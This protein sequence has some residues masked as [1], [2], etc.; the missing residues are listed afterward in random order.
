MSTK[1]KLKIVRL[2]PKQVKQLAKVYVESFRNKKEN[3]NKKQATKLIKNYLKKQPD[4]V[5]A[6]IF[7]DKLIG[8]YL[9]LIKPWWD[10]NHLV[11]TEL[12]VDPKFQK[13]GV[14]KKLFKA[15][16]LKSKKKYKATV[17]EGITFA[18]QNFPMNW[19]KC[20]GMRQSK[21]L[22]FIDGSINIMLRNIK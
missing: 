21:D 13:A 15:M 6:A 5:L 19:Y 18:K 11:E 14:G 7:K 4:M 10:G 3:W 9:C 17:I 8:G 2:Q 22:V 12:F 1:N 16:L 20:L